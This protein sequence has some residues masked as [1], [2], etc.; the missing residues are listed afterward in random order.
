M[1]I[2]LIVA[3]DEQGGIGKGS[4]LL[5][6]LPSDLAF[7]KKTTM[8]I[9]VIMGRKTHESIGRPL[10][11][12]LNIVV[13]RSN[14]L[15]ADGVIGVNSVEEA[16]MEAKKAN[17]SK[18]FVIGGGDIYRQFLPMANK[19]YLTRIHHT[20]EADTFFPSLN[21]SEWKKIHSQFQAK[22]DRNPWDHSFELW[23][24]D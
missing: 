16:V 14:H 1:E 19:I 15:Y 23:Q 22:D 11:G 3:A 10:P 5:C 21:E 12:R 2:S 4:S 8:G 24:K 6:H 13:S 9:P 17:S 18:V 7:F 20:F